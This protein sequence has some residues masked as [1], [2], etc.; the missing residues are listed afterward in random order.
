LV[1]VT[2]SR[3]HRHP[4]WVGPTTR[5][6]MKGVVCPGCT[7]PS[8]PEVGWRCTAGV[9]CRPRSAFGT[10]VISA[11]SDGCGRRP[12]SGR[13]R[14]SSGTPSGCRWSRQTVRPRGCAGRRPRGLR[15]IAGLFHVER[16]AGARRAD[17]GP[18]SAL[19]TSPLD[20]GARDHKDERRAA[21][22][23]TSRSAMCPPRR[24]VPSPCRGPPTHSALTCC[25]GVPRTE[26]GVSGGEAEAV[27]ARR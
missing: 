25:R 11:V 18:P 23:A 2:V 7:G 10:P 16:T 27:P 15:A 22:P 1:C 14:S 17:V 6:S 9:C 20:H 5:V 26:E 13:Y 12:T 3:V 8:L 24:P 21:Q 19:S 4:T